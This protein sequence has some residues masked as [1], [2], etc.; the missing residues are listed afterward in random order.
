MS[1]WLLIHVLKVFVFPS[2]TIAREGLLSFLDEVSVNS[3]NYQKLNFVKESGICY[4]NH[5]KFV[6]TGGM[7]CF[8]HLGCTRCLIVSHFTVKNDEYMFEV[9]R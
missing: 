8:R 5:A 7:K 2:A 4:I 3:M 1:P 9:K 6:Q